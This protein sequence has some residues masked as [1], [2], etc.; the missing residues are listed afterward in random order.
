ML[1]AGRLG[2]DALMLGEREFRVGDRVL[3]RQNDPRLGLR[4]GTR[5]T[6][7]DLDQT[8]AHAPYR[9][10]SAPTDAGR[11]R[12]EAP[13]P[14]LRPH[15]S[16]RPGSDGRPSLRP[17]R[18]P[19]SA[20]GV[21]LR[22]LLSRP[23]RD[24]PLPRDPAAR[25]RHARPRTAERPGPGAGRPRVDRLAPP[26][27]SRS[28][29]PTAIDARPSASSPCAS[30]SSSRQRARAEQRLADA[31]AK[32][33]RL[34]LARPSQTRRQA[35][36]RDR[37]PADRAPT[38]RRKARRA[39]VTAAPTSRSLPAASLPSSHASARGSSAQRRE[40]IEEV[41]QRALERERGFGLERSA[42]GRQPCS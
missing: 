16:R 33:D 41:R 23:Q 34:G 12:G 2:P 9:P 14:R 28:T 22:R 20:A 21:G 31:E 32:L 5:A 40:P 30:A 4:N 39:A 38:R 8:H 15:R 36:G 18:R 19:G 27:H 1:R 26:N 7:A 3:C 42:G 13:R 25:P 29:R 6:I 24:P 37:L 17:R 35:A 10:G 11:L